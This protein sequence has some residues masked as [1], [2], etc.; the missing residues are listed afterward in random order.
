M[1]FWIEGS[2]MPAWTSDWSLKV[3][4]ACAHMWWMSSEIVVAGAVK[5]NQSVCRL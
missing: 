4:V 3:A 5:P 2:S 1:S